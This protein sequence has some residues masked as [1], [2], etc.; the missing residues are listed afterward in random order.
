[1]LQRPRRNRASTAVRTLPRSTSLAQQIA[2]ELGPAALRA[3]RAEPR[4]PHL[5]HSGPSSA[6]HRSR[7]RAGDRL[8]IRHDGWS[9][10]RHSRARRGRLHADRHSELLR[11]VRIGIYGPFRKALERQALESATPAR[12]NGDTGRRQR[13][14]APLPGGVEPPLFLR[15]SSLHGNAAAS[16]SF[17]PKAPDARHAA[18]AVRAV[19]HDARGRGNAGSRGTRLAEN[20]AARPRGNSGPGMALPAWSGC[21]SGMIFSCGLS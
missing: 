21:W 16:S 20:A 3:G 15:G 19:E 2:A 1:M 5:L 12:S 9:G 7:A 10:G 17:R 18:R 4:E 8:S 14:P 13:S 11:E 6:R